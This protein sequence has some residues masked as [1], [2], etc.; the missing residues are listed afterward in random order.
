MSN[1]H[2]GTAHLKAA[3]GGG[4]RQRVVVDHSPQIGEPVILIEQYI[5]GAGWHQVSRP[6]SG[7]T[8]S[9]SEWTC[10]VEVRDSQNDYRHQVD[11]AE[12]SSFQDLS[13]VMTRY[14]EQLMF[15]VDPS[16]VSKVVLTA[17]PKNS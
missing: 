15:G 12:V 8:G 2:Q 17:I 10:S 9:D 11:L 7:L 13:S 3:S 14:A 1:T 6:S 4:A 16:T 5:P